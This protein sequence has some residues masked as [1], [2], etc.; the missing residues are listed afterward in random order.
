MYK[1]VLTFTKG[2]NTQ[3]RGCYTPEVGFI[4]ILELLKHGWAL[5]AIEVNE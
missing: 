2:P 3:E 1:Y 5:V 4:L